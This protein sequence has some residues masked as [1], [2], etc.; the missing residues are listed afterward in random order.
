MT[1]QEVVRILQEGDS[2]S[3]GNMMKE[4]TCLPGEVRQP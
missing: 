3:L 2:D 1:L 4:G